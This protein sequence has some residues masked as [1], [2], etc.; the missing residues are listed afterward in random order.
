[1]TTKL[2]ALFSFALSGGDGGNRHS[3]EKTKSGD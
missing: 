1:M 3:V 2:R